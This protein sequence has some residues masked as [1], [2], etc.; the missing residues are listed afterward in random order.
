[1]ADRMSVVSVLF[2]VLSQVAISQTLEEALVKFRAGNLAEAKQIYE[3]ILQKE[4]GNAEAHYRLAMIYLSRSFQDL[5]KAVEHVE[6]AVDVNPNNADYQYILG[7]AYGREA[8]SAGIFRKAILAP[9]VKAAF[10]KA[11]ELNP[12]HTEARIG[13]AQYYKQAPGIMGG[14]EKEAWK[15]L[16]EVMKIN[17]YRGRMVR[18]SFFEQDKKFAEA[19]DEYKKLTSSHPMEWRGWKNMGYFYLRQKRHDEAVKTMNKYVT[20]RPDTADSFESYAECLLRKGDTDLAITNLKKS[21]E[22]DK[23]FAPAFYLLAEAYEA[24]GQKKEAKE[25]Y[26]KVLSIDTNEN[27]RKNAEHKIKELQ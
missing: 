2:F 15:Q 17:E 26:Q 3:A 1:M 23:N 14:D 24:K 5:D 11:V 6:E 10:Q 9:K 8:Q 13:L 4:N 27:R 25:Y 22:L 20:L 7:A 18:A 16:D 21:L 19:D 12:R